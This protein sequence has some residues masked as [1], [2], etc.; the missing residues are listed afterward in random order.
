MLTE[1]GLIDVAMITTLLVSLIVDGDQ[2][3]VSRLN[4]KGHADQPNRSSRVTACILKDKPTTTPIGNSSIHLLKTFINADG[5]ETKTM[6]WHVMIHGLFVL[7]VL[8]LPLID[9]ITFHLAAK[10]DSRS[11]GC[12]RRQ[13]CA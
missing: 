8:A 13:C 10:P 7:L 12:S 4:R 9:R 3:F 11:S 5:S 2:A 1:L 6:L